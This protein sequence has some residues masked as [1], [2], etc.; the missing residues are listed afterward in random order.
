ME[1]PLREVIKACMDSREG[2]EC[3]D[4]L[5]RDALKN[6]STLEVL[7]LVQRFEAEDPEFRRDC[8]PVVHAIGEDLSTQRQYPRLFFSVRSDLSFRLL[9]WLRRAFLA[10]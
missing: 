7:Q 8:H 5:F 10:R 6:H 4:K 1:L 3:L 2:A 9:S